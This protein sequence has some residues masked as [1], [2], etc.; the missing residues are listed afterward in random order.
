MK[1]LTNLQFATDRGLL[2]VVP[3]EYSVPVVAV[4]VAAYRLIAFSGR[5]TSL[6]ITLLA[7]LRATT[8]SRLEL[9]AEID[10]RQQSYSTTL[11]T[12]QGRLANIQM[13]PTRHG[14]PRDLWASRENGDAP[15]PRSRR[16]NR[17]RDG[18]R[19][20]DYRTGWH[21]ARSSLQGRPVSMGSIDTGRGLVLPISPSRGESQRPAI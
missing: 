5:M 19:R 8:R 21:F 13:E 17:D 6:L 10:C 4:A 16:R 18:S 15:T 11:D 12:F 20:A 2:K 9:A 7:S 3:A 1:M 14:H